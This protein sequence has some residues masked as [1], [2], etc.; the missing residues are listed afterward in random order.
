MPNVIAGKSVVP[1]FI[2][3]DAKPGR[4]AAVA[5]ELLEDAPK[6]E[7]MQREL[8]DVVKSLGGPGASVRAAVA[9]LARLDRQPSSA[10]H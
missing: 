8:A 7:A 10:G 1:E 5:C 3:H 6:R 4:I 2:Q 9:I